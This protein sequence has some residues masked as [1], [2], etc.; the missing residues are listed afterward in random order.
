M[1]V[2]DTSVAPGSLKVMRK[3]EGQEWTADDI[4]MTIGLQRMSY[5]MVLRRSMGCLSLLAQH[6]LPAM[7][8]Q[9]CAQC[10]VHQAQADPV[11][12]FMAT[13]YAKWAQVCSH[14]ALVGGQPVPAL[15]STLGP[16]AC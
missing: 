5:A 10:S 1:S 9:P 12:S 11:V 15:G 14:M 16:C 8:S 4:H 7:H 3:F 6:H 13:G 2:K